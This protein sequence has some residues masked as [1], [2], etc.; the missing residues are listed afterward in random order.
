MNVPSAA[1]VTL[2]PAVVL[3]VPA[4]AATPPL[5]RSLAIRFVSEPTNGVAGETVVPPVMTNCVL[6]TM[7]LA[8]LYVSP[9]ATGAM[10]MENACE[11]V[12]RLTVSVAVM[13]KLKTPVAVGVPLIAPPAESDRPVGSEPSV[14]AKV[15]G[16]ALPLA[17]T[18]WPVYAVLKMPA[19]NEP[20]PVRATVMV[21]QV[22]T[23]V[24]VAPVPEQPFV[25]VAVTV[26]GNEPTALVVP[27]R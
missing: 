17:V 3:N 19:G 14:T 25:S 24:Y 26:I 1:M 13:V 7:W 6:S 18:L 11:P 2:P 21:G 5:G 20:P 15:N 16:P 27:A 23:N 10:L 22:T 8:A 4:V 9:T 12:Q